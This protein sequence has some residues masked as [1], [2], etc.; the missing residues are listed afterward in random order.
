MQER[1]DF[2]EYALAFFPG[3]QYLLYHKCCI[4]CDMGTYKKAEKV[5]IQLEAIDTTDIDNDTRAKIYRL[6]AEIY[7]A[8][9]E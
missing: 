7:A 1:D 6:G 9:R 2:I 3:D 4:L 8:L 5:L